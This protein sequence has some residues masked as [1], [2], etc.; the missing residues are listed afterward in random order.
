MFASVTLGFLEDASMKRPDQARA[1][2]FES[3]NV[4]EY[5]TTGAGRSEYPR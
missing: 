4:R 3:L 1:L 2:D 5:V